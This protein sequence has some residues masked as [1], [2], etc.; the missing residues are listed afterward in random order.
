M[1]SSSMVMKQKVSRQKPR[2]TSGK[3]K[4]TQECWKSSAAEEEHPFRK[5]PVVNVQRPRTAKSQDMKFREYIKNLG[6]PVSLTNADN[7]GS[8][9]L[10]EE[11]VE[12]KEPV[13]EVSEVP[14]AEAESE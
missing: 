5:Q 14:A 10:R 9:Q 4:K 7:I 3:S 6:I 13:V 11:I 12:S 1:L 2:H 8:E